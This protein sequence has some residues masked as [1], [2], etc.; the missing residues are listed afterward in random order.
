MMEALSANAQAT[1][2][3]TAPLMFGGTAQ[4]Y[5]LLT[6]KEWNRLSSYLQDMGLAPGNLITTIPNELQQDAIIDPSRLRQLLERGTLLSQALGHWQSRGIWV[7]DRSD[8]RY[9]QRLLQRLGDKAPGILY[10]CGPMQH[11]HSGG[12]AIVG[13]RHV[14]ATLA[15]YAFAA[16]QQAAN[17]GITTISGGAIGIDQAAMRGA[18]ETGGNV[19]GVL[20]DSLEKIILQRDNRDL[21]QG[22]RLLLISPYDP[23]ASFNAGNAMQR[24]KL[25]Y[26]LADAA[27]VVNADLNRGGTWGG[28]VE[29][30]DKIKKIPIYIRTSGT[31]FPACAPLLNKGGLPW[32]D[33]ENAEQ[34]HRVFIPVPATEPPPPQQ[35][36]LPLNN[37][38]EL[39]DPLALMSEFSNRKKQTKSNPSAHPRIRNQGDPAE[40]LFAH[41]R[42]L[43]LE[44]LIHPMKESH[45]AEILNLSKQQNKVWLERLVQMGDLEKQSKPSGTYRLKQKKLFDDIT[46]NTE[47]TAP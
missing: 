31:T 43:L 17:A 46:A 18:L 38:T 16:G 7:M 20:T 27:L 26:L 40:L 37:T 23:G 8:P 2:L 24:N 22:N 11:L 44:L 42:E 28:A 19:V 41:V 35:S 12:L 34:L 30:L 3:L 25:I 13:S 6:P 15:N 14:D 47:N 29:Q 45:I 33:P 39:A 9:P 32:P 21:I 1:L 10:G 36:T 5:P 4:P